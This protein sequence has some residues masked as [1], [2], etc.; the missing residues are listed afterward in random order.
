MCRV[1]VSPSVISRAGARRSRACATSPSKISAGRKSRLTI[2]PS[3][4]RR[5]RSS[6]GISRARRRRRACDKPI[7]DDDPR[8]VQPVFVEPAIADD[9]IA[10]E[11]FFLAEDLR[12]PERHQ[13]GLSQRRRHCPFAPTPASPESRGS[14][15]MPPRCRSRESRTASSSTKAHPSR[16]HRWLRPGPCRAPSGCSAC[17]HDFANET[18]APK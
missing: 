10:R 16:P 15:A 9:R 13:E 11:K 17:R 7:S 3:R 2:N 6:S 14:A 1:T 4:S 18:E 12:H 8:R 5:R